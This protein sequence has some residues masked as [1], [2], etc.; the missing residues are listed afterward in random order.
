MSPTHRQTEEQHHGRT[1]STSSRSRRSP[2]TSSS[3]RRPATCRTRCCRSR[4][5]SCAGCAPARSTAAATAPTCT[6]RTRSPPARTPS[7]STWSRRGARRPAS[8]RP[9][10]PPWS[11]PS[12][13]PGSPTRPGVTDEVWLNAS[14]HYD[15]EQLAALLLLVATI[16]AFNRLNVINQQPAGELR[17]R[18][19]RRLRPTTEHVDPARTLRRVN[20]H[21]PLRSAHV[22]VGAAAS[23]ALMLIGVV[24]FVGTLVWHGFGGDSDKYGRIDVP[25]SGT[26]TLPE[27]RSTST[28]RSGWPPTVVAARSP[29][30]VSASAW[31]PPKAPAT[32]W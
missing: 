17:D 21:G 26:V 13:A 12:R 32:R 16:N 30:P 24:G 11:S 8:P 22:A 23:V 29:C 15:D 25:G 28:S 3:S 27:V 4:R 5:R 1:Q 2:G 20:V 6:S 10:G 19:V 14:K 18:S 9:S 31:R 7:G